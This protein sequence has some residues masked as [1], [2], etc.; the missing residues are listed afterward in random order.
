LRADPFDEFAFTDAPLAT[1]SENG[2]FL[3]FDHA[4]HCSPRNTATQ[5]FPE[6]SATAP[7]PQ[8][9]FPLMFPRHPQLSNANAMRF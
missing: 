2:Q 9:H 8:D 4:L 5:R 7:P 1:D 6:A 3:A